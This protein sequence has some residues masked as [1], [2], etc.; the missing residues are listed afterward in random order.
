MHIFGTVTNITL[1]HILHAVLREKTG[2]TKLQILNRFLVIKNIA[3]NISA[4]L[5]DAFS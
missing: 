4:I 2:K 3:T 1:W 5:L